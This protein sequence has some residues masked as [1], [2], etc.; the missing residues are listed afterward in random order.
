MQPVAFTA[1]AQ[2]RGVRSVDAIITAQ[3]GRTCVQ[4]HTR[5]RMGQRAAHLA[6]RVTSAEVDL[7]SIL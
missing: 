3:R 4:V 6:A 7:E 1:E 2:T 5:T